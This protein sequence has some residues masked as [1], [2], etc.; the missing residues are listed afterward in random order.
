MNEIH[1]LSFIL[2]ILLDILSLA[3]WIGKKNKY[4]FVQVVIFLL[5]TAAMYGYC[6]HWP[7]QISSSISDAMWCAGILC[8]TCMIAQMSREPFEQNA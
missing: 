5:G 8:V 6:M 3:E 4:S 7:G 1:Q 2:I